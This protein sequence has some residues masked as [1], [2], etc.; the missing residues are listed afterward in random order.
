[1]AESTQS[2]ANAIIAEA[3]GILVPTVGTSPT[4]TQMS[5]AYAATAVQTTTMCGIVLARGRNHHEL[6]REHIVNDPLQ[7]RPQHRCPVIRVHRCRHLRPLRCHIET[8]AGRIV[9]QR[10][11]EAMTPSR[12]IAATATMLF[13]H[14]WLKYFTNDDSSCSLRALLLVL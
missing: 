11:T 12:T 8:T 9:A 13:E 6:D 2:L 7:A 14:S 10:A 1:M 4:S 5:W 3:G